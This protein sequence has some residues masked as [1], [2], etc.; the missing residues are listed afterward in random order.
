MCDPLRRDK[1]TACAPNEYRASLTFRV[2]DPHP[3]YPRHLEDHRLVIPT[4]LD[5]ESLELIKQCLAASAGTWFLT[6]VEVPRGDDLLTRSSVKPIAAPAQPAQNSN[7]T[8]PVTIG[9]AK[10]GP[11]EATITFKS[12]ADKQRFIE[13]QLQA[14]DITGLSI[15][16]KR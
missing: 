1:L 2:P 5:S 13:S 16:Y 6:S 11:I 7:L 14:M 10:G 15:G 4:L 3:N 12:E 8:F 9:C